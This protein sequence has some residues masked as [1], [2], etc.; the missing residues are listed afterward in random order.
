MN[1]E[2]QIP[3]GLTSRQG[4]I[5]VILVLFGG[6]AVWAWD[7]YQEW[8]ASVEVAELHRR[9]DECVGLRATA[10]S[11]LTAAK[12][13]LAE[14]QS[15]ALLDAYDAQQKLDEALRAEKGRT[16][17]FL[18][19]YKA[20]VDRAAAQRESYRAAKSN[21]DALAE[22]RNAVMSTATALVIFVKQWRALTPYMCAMLDGN[23]E[24][25]D[26]RIRDGD[27]DDVLNLLQRVQDNFT[28][29]RE[30]IRTLVN[31]AVEKPAT[32]S[33]CLCTPPPTPK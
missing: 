33:P 1:D 32:A 5:Y 26:Q 3:R 17:Q 18:D 16:D 14:C 22:K 25:M 30:T 28:G 20:L 10:D 19:E 15:K 24:A 2:P 27:A 23:I 21:P 9:V 8:S 7:R 31:Q 12:N 6:A 13:N 29:Q 4:F 11:G